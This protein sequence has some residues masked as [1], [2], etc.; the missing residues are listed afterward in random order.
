MLEAFHLLL[1]LLFSAFGFEKHVVGIFELVFTFLLLPV[2]TPTFVLL[3]MAKCFYQL[4]IRVRAS[5]CCWSGMAAI[6]ANS[7]RRSLSV[8]FFIKCSL[9]RGR[10]SGGDDS[11]DL[12][13]LLLHYC[14]DNNQVKWIVH[15]FQVRPSTTWTVPRWLFAL[16]VG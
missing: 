16:P 12:L 3:V 15:F 14:V 7:L 5:V 1:D 4:V 9:T 8:N 6:A 2:E 11:N 10:F 13:V